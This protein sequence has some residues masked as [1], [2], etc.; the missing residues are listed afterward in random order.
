MI[1]GFI[2]VMSK[3][4]IRLL[5]LDT[6]TQACSIAVSQGDDL[7]VESTIVTR[8]TH[9]RHLLSLIRDALDRAGFKVSDLDGI[10]VTRGPG[11]FTGLRIGISTAKG[12]AKAHNIPLLG[13][14][15]LECLAW[16]SGMIDGVVCALMDARRDEVYFAL[17]QFEH[18][19][20]K[21]I[22]P[23]SVGSL[24]SLLEKIDGHCL[25]IGNGVYLYHQVIASR[26]GK[27]AAFSKDFNHVLRANTVQYVARLKM[28][29]GI[30]SLSSDLVPTYIR[31]SDAQINMEKR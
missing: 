4:H 29:A 10:V 24:N 27:K 14:S 22:V 23:D 16:Q 26:M 11:S 31:K 1:V 12:L 25:F 6:A 7:I 28:A 20:I 2:Y 13:V 17:Y 30:S 18:S 8:Q 9:S 19:K 21:T 3:S 15:Y 5:S